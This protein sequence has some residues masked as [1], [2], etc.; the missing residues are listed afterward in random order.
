MEDVA[1]LQSRAEVLQ[2]YVDAAEV[3]VEVLN[4]RET[5]EGQSQLTT[6]TSVQRYHILAA[7]PHP[8][9]AIDKN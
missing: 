2:G 5:G 6:D 1:A 4:L 9:A 8:L 3:G 7:F